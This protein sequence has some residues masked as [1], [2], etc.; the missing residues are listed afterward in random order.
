M[1]KRIFKY[2]YGPVS[3]WRLGRS[4]GIDPLSCGQKVCSFDC[5]YCQL[6]KTKI[7]SV[8]RKTYVDVVDIIDEIDS[9]PAC[10]IDYI[11]FAGAGEPTLAANLYHMIRA[12]KETRKE[13]VAV[14][15]NSSLLTREDVRGDLLLAD[16]VVAK[17]DA[18]SSS[19]FK[20]INRPHRDVTFE[21]VLNGLKLFRKHY[22]HT[23]ALQIMCI[24]ENKDSAAE[25]AKCAR[26]IM[27]DE[28][29]INTPLRPCGV[30]PLSQKEIK[31]LSAHFTGLNT[32]S[33]YDAPHQKVETMSDADTLARR[34][35]V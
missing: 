16:M 18:P 21:A 5:V 6:G 12:I 11:T 26:E 34:G 13:K 9:L 24:D 23:L 33:V 10:Q 15:T 31:E 3:S 28:V 29:E 14:I 30:N 19:L 1:S 7:S 35:K 20:S 8:E 27:P 17:L 32:V 2:L 4:L 25:L 22:K